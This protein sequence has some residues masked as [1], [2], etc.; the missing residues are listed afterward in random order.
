MHRS[1]VAFVPLGPQKASFHVQFIY[2]YAYLFFCMD[3]YIR[4][5]HHNAVC[6]LS[7]TFLFGE[8]VL[9]RGGLDPILPSFELVRP[10]PT[11]SWRSV[12]ERCSKMSA[13]MWAVS[14]G[15]D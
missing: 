12:W 10:L 6:I 9:G 13:C 14:E 8:I 3:N 1:E 7:I 15:Q 4:Y 2:M 11:L 5:I